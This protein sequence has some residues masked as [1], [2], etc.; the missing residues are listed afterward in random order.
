MTKQEEILFLINSLNIKLSWL[1][2]KIEVPLPSL[3]F[4]LNDS[5]KFD[6]ELYSIIK[7]AIKSY[8]FELNFIDEKTT[9]TTPDLFDEQQIK[10]GIGERLRVFANRRFNTLKALAEEM[11][12]SP[13]QLQ[14][15]ISG[16]REPGSKILI[17]LLKLGCDINWLLGGFE[18][19]ES[20]KIFKLESEV[21]KLQSAVLKISQLTDE[22]LHHK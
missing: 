3:N 6:D 5:D 13:Q 1:A 8:Q 18:S 12:I 16:N 2:D 15:Y 10:K 11:H 21:K 14:Q 19:I 4:L 22:T 20:Y 9:T 17:K 7:E